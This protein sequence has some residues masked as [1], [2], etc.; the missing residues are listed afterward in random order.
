MTWLLKIGAKLTLGF[1]VMI[2]MMAIIGLNGYRSVGKVER[3]L[4]DIFAVR[5]PSIDYL[6]QA[7]RDL[8]QSLVAERSM[9]FANAKSDLF[10]GLVKDYE[11]N[12]KQSDE[13]WM[14]FKAI[15]STKEEA[16]LIANYEKARKEW[17]TV[18]RKVVDG[19]IA[20][21]RQGRREALDLT[22]GQAKEKFEAMRDYLDKLT[23][24]NLKMAGEARQE[25]EAT[26]KKTVITVLC[27]IGLGILIGL[28]FAWSLARGITRPLKAVIEGLSEASGQVASGSSQVASSSQ[29][30]AEG[31]SEQAASIEETSSSLEE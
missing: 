15:A 8:Q 29:Q 9:I 5:L 13:R 24:L 21:T 19:R 10:K 30:L 6:I 14:K 1:A 3:N 22:L 4:D 31:A 11:E 18:S 17:K 2:L 26:Y 16:V 23:D 28:V 27:S 7:D 20:D 12:V 25:A